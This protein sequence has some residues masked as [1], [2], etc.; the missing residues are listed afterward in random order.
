MSL[1]DQLRPEARNAP[2]SGIVAVMNHGRRQEG[3]L[4]L[5]AGEGDLPT[6]EFISEAAGRALAAF[7]T[8]ADGWPPH[9]GPDG[10][11]AASAGA[12][13]FSPIRHGA[14]LPPRR[15]DGGHA[16]WHGSGAGRQRLPLPGF[17]PRAGG[18]GSRSPAVA[19]G[20][21]GLRRASGS[22]AAGHVRS[23]GGRSGCRWARSGDRRKQ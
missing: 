17:A 16:G 8:G 7:A 19:S 21:A 1:I 18:D 22:R 23:V 10:A 3:V 4:P 5:W 12:Q 2:E 9:A 11:I 15:P 6:P 14:V 13:H 20:A